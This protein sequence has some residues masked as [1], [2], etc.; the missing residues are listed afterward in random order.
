MPVIKHWPRSS[1]QC[2]TIPSHEWSLRL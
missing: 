1:S 2:G